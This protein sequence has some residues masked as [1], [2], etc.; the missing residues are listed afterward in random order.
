MTAKPS[1]EKGSGPM[2]VILPG[3]AL[4]PGDYIALARML[5]G[6]VR[7]L[8]S[9][10]TAV[11]GEV[12]TIRVAITPENM[13]TDSVNAEACFEHT[14]TGHDNRSPSSSAHPQINLIGHSVGADAA[15]EW[16]L[17][18]PAEIRSVVLIDPPYPHRA[19]RILT[20]QSKARPLFTPFVAVFE[21]LAPIFGNAT[22]RLAIRVATRRADQLNRFDATARYS[23]VKGASTIID[24]WFESWINRIACGRHLASE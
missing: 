16:A 15:L 12:E 18:Y 6:P 3:L 23:T 19:P 22:R 9:W 4:A 7:I 20:E 24:Q 10:H 5:P 11:T 2:W 1:M 21:A 13:E 14:E 8:D 17:R